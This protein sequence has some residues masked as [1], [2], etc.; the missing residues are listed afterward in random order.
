MMFVSLIS[1]QHCDNTLS[2]I[3][4]YHLQGPQRTVTQRKI[5]QVHSNKQQ[6]SDSLLQKV[7]REYIAKPLNNY[8]DY[9]YLHADSMIPRVHYPTQAHTPSLYI[10][11]FRHF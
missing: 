10:I 8:H 9:F 1:D 5:E 7:F 11:Y 4:N 3:T 6:I 2:I